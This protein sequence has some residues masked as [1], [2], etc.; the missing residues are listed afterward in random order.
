MEILKGT[1]WMNQDPEVELDKFL[2][3]N[4]D[5]DVDRETAVLLAK[6]FVEWY[7]N[8]LMNKYHISGPRGRMG[9][10]PE[11]IRKR[12]DS[13]QETMNPPYDAMDICT[14]YEKGAM[15]QEKVLIDNGIHCKV[16]WVDGPL[17]TYTQEQ[18]DDV[19]EEIG[20]DID[21]D[22]SVIIKKL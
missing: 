19:L 13:F 6:H 11:D 5:I 22:V 2:K 14:A 12:A 10:V 15:D 21:D 9:D 18:Q 17:L 7:Q 3:E 16:D 8:L 4:P 1:D 20:A